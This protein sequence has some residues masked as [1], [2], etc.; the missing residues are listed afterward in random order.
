MK[1]AVF[2]FLICM[3]V[4]AVPASEKPYVEFLAGVTLIRSNPRLE[5]GQIARKY[6]QLEAICKVKGADVLKFIRKYKDKPKQWKE[7]NEEIMDIIMENKN[8]MPKEE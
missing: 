2:I 8:K 7:V 5:N 1:T 6:Q 4:G 3:W